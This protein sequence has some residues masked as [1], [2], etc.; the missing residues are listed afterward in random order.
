MGCSWRGG[1]LAGGRSARTTLLANVIVDGTKFDS[2]VANDAEQQK[3]DENG[4]EHAFLGF[5]LRN[6]RQGSGAAKNGRLTWIRGAG[7]QGASDCGGIVTMHSTQSRGTHGR[8]GV[9]VGAHDHR[10]GRIAGR[11][12]EPA[13]VAQG[14]GP[15]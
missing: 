1:G 4:A 11:C 5:G 7:G 15:L 9:Y 14:F 8:G 3:R 2:A 10:G 12:A 6:G 13:V